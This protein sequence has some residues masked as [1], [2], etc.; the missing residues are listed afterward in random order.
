MSHYDYFVFD[1]NLVGVGRFDEKRISLLQSKMNKSHSSDAINELIE[2][3][4]LA[5]YL[6]AL[7]KGNKKDLKELYTEINKRFYTIVT[8]ESIDHLEEYYQLSFI[9]L[10]ITTKT[11]KNAFQNKLL[12]QIYICNLL[13][14]KAIVDE[15]P[16]YIIERIKDNPLNFEYI[17]SKL[18]KNN[19]I[20]IPEGDYTELCV[21][22]MN[23]PHIHPDY[24]Q[25][26][27]QGLDGMN[28]YVKGYDEKLKLLAKSTYDKVVN[29]MIDS[30]GT[31]RGIRLLVTTT[32]QQFEYERRKA[33]AD[34]EICCTTF[35]NEEWLHQNRE[36]A[37]VLNYLLFHEDIFTQD[38]MF[39]SVNNKHEDSITDLFGI[40]TKDGKE[41]KGN[42]LFELNFRICTMVIQV[43]DYILESDHNSIIS[44]AEYYFNTYTK[45][46]YRV[47]FPKYPK[48][49][50]K[51][52]IQ[53]KIAA[54]SGYI[55]HILKCWK[56]FCNTRDKNIKPEYVNLVSEILR[57]KPAWLI[58][59]KYA[60]LTLC[61]EQLAQI[62]MSEQSI[63]N[64]FYYKENKKCLYDLILSDTKINDN[65]DQ[66]NAELELLR[67]AGVLDRKEGNW[68]LVDANKLK[69][70]ASLWSQPCIN[71]YYYK[72][73]TTK[74]L[75][76]NGY[77][78]TYSGLLSNE[79]F[80]L[81]QYILIDNFRDSLGIRNK[82]AHGLPLYQNIDR[83][84]NDY[85][86]V[87][88][89]LV[90]LVIKIDDELNQFINS[91]T[92]R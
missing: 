91:K 66:I 88:V 10:L 15:Y 90:M 76:N 61:G 39:K 8:N 9:E 17:I 47:Q 32:R 6:K 92:G 31:K 4:N 55:E 7:N 43:I 25:I 73:D 62:I 44:L 42:I 27:W 45:K 85:Y 65:N 56:V 52:D 28:R 33:V 67:I 20:Y 51:L 14:K 63:T 5:K 74:Y 83:Y 78:T 75:I 30:Y 77:I 82:Y 24:L 80:N 50:K 57:E 54:I 21:S 34:E 18:I 29:T 16:D 58:D 59:D 71:L 49:K 81:L 23:H 87:L 35:V 13:K 40:K 37:S 64:Q 12:D 79:E 70:F 72:K 3:Y 19:D 36:K 2:F 46:V 11:L 60:T 41:Y 48:I 22:F 1:K 69:I 38:R 89:I 86:M 26:I 53:Y 84:K 68:V